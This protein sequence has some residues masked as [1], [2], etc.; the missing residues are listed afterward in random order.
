MFGFDPTLRRCPKAAIDPL[1]M[2]WLD[3]YSRFRAVG[4]L[5]EPG[6]WG[7]QPAV[8]GEAFMMLEVATIQQQQADQK[9]ALSKAKPTPM[10]ED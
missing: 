2:S 8:V 10:E 1:A 9:A 7:D 3:L 4:Q 5:P 6:E